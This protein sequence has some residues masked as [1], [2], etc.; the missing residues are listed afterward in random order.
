MLSSVQPMVG[1][2]L[3]DAGDDA[4]ELVHAFGE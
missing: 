3:C 1:D 2:V 4:M